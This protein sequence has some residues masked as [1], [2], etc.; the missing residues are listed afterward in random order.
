M[1][2]EEGKKMINYDSTIR[3]MVEDLKNVSKNDKPEA[4]RLFNT[5]KNLFSE[6]K[7]IIRITVPESYLEDIP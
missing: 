6:W 2:I 5:I 3:Q 1:K 7:K 4:A